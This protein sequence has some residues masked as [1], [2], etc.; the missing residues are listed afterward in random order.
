[1]KFGN[2]NKFIIKNFGPIKNIEIENKKLTI[3][4]GPQASGKSILAKLMTIFYD[5]EFIMNPD[6][7]KFLPIYNIEFLEPDTY[8]EYQ[9]DDEFYIRYS[10]GKCESNLNVESNLNLDTMADNQLDNIIKEAVGKAKNEG[11]LKSDANENSYLNLL[12]SLTQ[13]HLRRS[14]KLEIK[15]KHLATPLYIPTERTVVASI[16]DF[17]F[18]F[19]KSNINLPECVIDFGARFENARAKYNKYII[20]F[21]SNVE[22][23]F[24]NNQNKLNIGNGQVI[25]FTQSSSGMQ[26]VIPMALLIES[27]SNE[28]KTANFV[29]E[30]PELNLYPV[31]QKKLVEFISAKCLKDNSNLIITTHSPYILTSFANLIQAHNVAQIS[32]THKKKVAAIIPEESWIDFEN[33]SVYYIDNGTATDI[34][35]YENKTINATAID[36]VSEMIAKEFE[37]LLNLKYQ[38]EV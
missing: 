3:L 27:F 5:I 2:N 30:E 37:T 31:T 22:Y 4:I 14:L 11:T 10:N 24:E 1:M 17:L 29:I 19:I 23:S 21:L 7:N 35:D 18:N 20:P 8:L 25:N 13:D 6:I 9:Y 15:D 16:S 36:D 28:N 33:V 32:P 12:K 26:A 38:D 34:L